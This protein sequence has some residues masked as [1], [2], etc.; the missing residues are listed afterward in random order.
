MSVDKDGAGRIAVERRRQID[1]EGYGDAHD[2]KHDDGSL[3]MAAACYAASAGKH[4]IYRHV[5]GA[6]SQTFVDPWPWDRS[7]DKRPFTVMDTLKKMT[8]TERLDLLVKAGALIAAEIDRLLRK[9]SKKSERER[10][11]RE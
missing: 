1:V 10:R 8:E 11:Y 3:A 4:V 7:C 5:I 2:D 6:L 9:R